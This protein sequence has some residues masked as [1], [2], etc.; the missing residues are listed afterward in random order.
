MVSCRIF[1]GVEELMVNVVVACVSMPT[2]ANTGVSSK[3][4]GIFR[5]WIAD[6]A[7]WDKILL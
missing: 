1:A 2:H 3:E 5:S 6:Y 7:I 4:P